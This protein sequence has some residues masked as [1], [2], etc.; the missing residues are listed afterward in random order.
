MEP[1]SMSNLRHAARGSF[2]AVKLCISALVLPCTPD[3]QLDFL[4]D[5]IQ[6]SESLCDLLD[7]LA[8]AFADDAPGKSH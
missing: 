6:A 1:N 3:E 2:N 5:V 7:S 8:A 4:D